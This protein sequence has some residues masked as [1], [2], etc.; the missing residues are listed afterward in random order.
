MKLFYILFAVAF[1][2]EGYLF[3]RFFSL[4]DDFEKHLARRHRHNIVTKRRKRTIEEKHTM[5]T[6]V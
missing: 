2:A 1:L 5:A 4:V 6:P 3:Y